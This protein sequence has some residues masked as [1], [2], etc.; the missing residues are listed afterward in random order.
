MAADEPKQTV[1]VEQ[2]S[3]LD[4]VLTYLKE[5][6]ESPF[7]MSFLFSWSVINRDFLF[8]LFLADDTNKH[9][10]LSNWDFSGFICNF[11]LFSWHSHWADSFWFPLFYGVMITLF[12][13]SVSSVL[14]GGRYFFLKKCISFAKSHKDGVETAYA[15]KLE[16]MRLELLKL[17]RKNLEEQSTVLQSK[18]DFI[19]GEYNHAKSV[20]LKMNLGDVAIFLRDSAN[21]AILHK[22]GIHTN[23]IEFQAD[24]ILPN[25]VINLS[26]VDKVDKGTQLDNFEGTAFD[27]MTNEKY[28]DWGDDDS[29][30]MLE[31]VLQSLTIEVPVNCTLNKLGRVRCSLIKSTGYK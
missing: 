2:D 1:V 19:K 18:V 5:R 30:A 31:G 15:I 12:F 10:Q 20:K 4:N 21:F 22:A 28:F 27:F 7:L 25:S 24:T 13:S 8:Y 9:N 23:L 16:Q 6:I 29:L 3:L 11:E 26:I 17:E 14:S